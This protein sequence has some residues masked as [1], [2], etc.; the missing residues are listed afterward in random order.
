MCFRI[1]NVV[2][3]QYGGKR[4]MLLIIHVKDEKENYVLQKEL[5]PYFYAHQKKN[6][7]YKLSIA[8]I[9]FVS[10]TGYSQNDISNNQEATY[11]KEVKQTILEFFEG[12]HSGDTT[13]IKTTLDKNIVM[14]TIV[15]TKEGEVRT[16]KTDVEKI[17]IAIKNRPVEQKWDERLLSFKIDADSSIAN[18]WTPYEF[19]VNENFSHC[20]VNIFQLFND[21]NRWKIIAIADTRNKVGCKKK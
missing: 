1:V 5:K 21:G 13:K 11:K 12:F 16:V 18:A 6:V 7:M 4:I 8:V 17:L 10:F 9:L 20:G 19:Y 14:Q 2:N 15:K 3:Y